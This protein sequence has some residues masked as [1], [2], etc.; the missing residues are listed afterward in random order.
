MR[1]LQRP[2]RRHPRAGQ[3]C[4]GRVA[5]PARRRGRPA[6]AGAG[7]AAHGGRRRAD[8]FAGRSGT[9]GPDRSER[10]L[11]LGDLSARQLTSRL[12]DDGLYL[13]TGRF[14]TRIQSSIPSV[15]HGLGLLY[16]DYPLQQAAQFADFHLRLA[17]PANGRRW[18]RPQVVL[19]QDGNSRFRPL[20]LAHAFPMFEWGLNW[21]ISSR[22]H[23][24]LMLHAAVV[25]KDSRAAILPAPPG[26]G[27]STL[28]A[29]LV[30]N[31]WR[32]LS[33]ELTLVRVSDGALVALARPISLKNQSIAL[34]RQFQPGVVA[35]RPV[36][37]T[38][39]GTLAHVR[40]PSA[41]VA[42]AGQT[43]RAAWIV[44]PRY[45]AGAPVRLAPLTRARAFMRVA[46]NCFNYSLLG[47][48]GFDVLGELVDAAHCYDFS[49]S[50]LDAAVGAIEQLAQAQP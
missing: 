10:M 50:T 39:K 17:R 24:Y 14:V 48:R 13:E 25:E 26:S 42:N 30:H 19:F 1:A 21:C 8:A 2:L 33:D 46:D 34:I 31:G 16:G 20:P 36:F 49:Y 44:F 37:E 32:L 35:S 41:S 43:C 3:R 47:A 27:K 22:A 4:F 38:Q 15:A 11:K 29:A 9:A 45:E 12:A 6:R 28:C 5:G 23:D 18:F 7:A 40:P